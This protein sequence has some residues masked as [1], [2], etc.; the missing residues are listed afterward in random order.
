VLNFEVGGVDVVPMFK[1]ELKL[2]V[3]GTRALCSEHL[4]RG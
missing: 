3:L 4:W 1:M 2:S